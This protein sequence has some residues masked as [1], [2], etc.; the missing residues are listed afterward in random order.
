MNS[1]FNEDLIEKFK[2]MGMTENEIFNIDDS[3]CPINCIELKK[4]ERE[5]VKKLFDKYS[6]NDLE[7]E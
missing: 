4:K 3:K 1:L 5:Y 6:I 7:K 2:E